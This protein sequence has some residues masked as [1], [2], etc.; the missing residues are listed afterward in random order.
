MTPYSVSGGDAVALPFGE[1][2]PGGVQ[3][4]IGS[5]DLIPGSFGGLLFNPEATTGSVPFITG[6]AFDAYVQ[7][8]LGL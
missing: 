4:Y 1:V 3:P 6:H 7:A 8:F 5:G 2:A